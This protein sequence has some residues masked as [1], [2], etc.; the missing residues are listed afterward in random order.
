[1]IEQR[2]K[3]PNCGEISTFD[4]K[5]GETKVVTCSACDLKGRVTIPG[6]KQDNTVAIEVSHLKKVYGDLTA[7]NDISFSVKTGEI[8]A[9]LGPNGAGKTTTVEMIESIRQPTAGSIK[10]LGKDIKTQFNDVKKKSESFHKSSIPL[11]D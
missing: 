4:G 2:F 8:F 10:L 9:F 5:P 1:M 6:E 3:C 11:K 7:V